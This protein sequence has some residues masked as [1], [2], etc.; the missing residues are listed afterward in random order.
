MHILIVVNI[1]VFSCHKIEILNGEKIVFSPQTSVLEMS[2]SSHGHNMIFCLVIVSRRHFQYIRL[3]TSGYSIIQY[4]LQTTVNRSYK[5]NEYIF[6]MLYV[7]CLL[8]LFCI[9]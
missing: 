8:L 6:S 7:Y 2:T 3:R 5:Q 4:A 9:R 1:I